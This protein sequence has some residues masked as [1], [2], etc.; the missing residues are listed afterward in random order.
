ML[1]GSTAWCNPETSGLNCN[2]TP[3]V[4]HLYG[5]I[6][7]SMMAPHIIRTVKGWIPFWFTFVLHITGSAIIFYDL[8]LE[9]AALS[10]YVASSLYLSWMMYLIFEDYKHNMSFFESAVAL[11]LSMNSK[12]VVVEELAKS[13]RS[14]LQMILANVAHDLKTPLQGF[15]FGIDVMRDTRKENVLSQ[16]IHN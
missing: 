3:G 14:S 11:Q 2:P 5:Y 12:L 15:R 7:I 10:Y 13:E 4:P 1:L 16:L 9:Q 6:Q 8:Y